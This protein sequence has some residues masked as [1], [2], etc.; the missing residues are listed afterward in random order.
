MDDILY[1]KVCVFEEEMKK[2]N[3]SCLE[4]TSEEIVRQLLLVNDNF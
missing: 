1:N 3:K 2:I 4:T